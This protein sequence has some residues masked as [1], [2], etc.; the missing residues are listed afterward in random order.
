MNRR[1]RNGQRR[2]QCC[3]VVFCFVFGFISANPTNP[4]RILGTT[5]IRQENQ[6]SGGSLPALVVRHSTPRFVP[7]ACQLL[8]SE[9]KTNNASLEKDAIPIHPATTNKRTTT[10]VVLCCAVFF[11]LIVVVTV[12]APS[13]LVSGTLFGIDRNLS[14][15]E[16]IELVRVGVKGGGELV[17]NGRVDDRR[18]RH[19]FRGC[20]R[21]HRR[22]VSLAWF[23]RPRQLAGNTRIGRWFLRSSSSGSS[24]LV[25]LGP[26]QPENAIVVQC[27]GVKRRKVGR[28]VAVAALLVPGEEFF[29]VVKVCLQNVVELPEVLDGR[30]PAGPAKGL[31]ANGVLI[32]QDVDPDRGGGLHV[33]GRRQR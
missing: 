30:I 1:C 2:Q 6:P 33:R 31:G 12:V 10:T 9:P 14:R 7:Y 16:R 18:R 27:V 20:R 25:Q 5:G 15:V 8:V 19:A 22:L 24:N 29:L 11:S 4:E 32:V 3:C 21:R 26:G 28:L 23:S 13:C 17:D